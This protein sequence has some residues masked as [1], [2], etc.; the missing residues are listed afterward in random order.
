VERSPIR[1]PAPIILSRKIRLIVSRLVAPVTPLL[2]LGLGIWIVIRTINEEHLSLDN[3][4]SN[5]TAFW[6]LLAGALV[7]GCAPIVWRQFFDRERDQYDE[8]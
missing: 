3:Q 2:G 6:M 4:V 1:T 5:R 8:D 7:F